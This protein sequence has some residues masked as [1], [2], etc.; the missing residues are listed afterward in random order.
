[1]LWVK[2]EALQSVVHKVLQEYEYLDRK[3]I[4]NNRYDNL[5]IHLPICVPKDH[6]M[7]ILPGEECVALDYM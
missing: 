3:K 2:E 1:M 6:F 4:C 7:E 5:S